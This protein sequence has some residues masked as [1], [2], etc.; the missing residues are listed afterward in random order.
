MHDYVTI[1][2]K[3]ILQKSVMTGEKVLIPVS[4]SSEG[5][6]ASKPCMTSSMINHLQSRNHRYKEHVTI[7]KKNEVKK[8]FSSHWTNI[9][10][11]DIT[12]V[13]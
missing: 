6:K 9:K 2:A 13:L 10:V 3:G 7:F 11:A 8:T 5:R 4:I 1:W 12:R